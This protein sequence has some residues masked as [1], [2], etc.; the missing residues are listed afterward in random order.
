MKAS[1]EFWKIHEYAT[2]WTIH[3]DFQRVH[4]MLRR[5]R[6]LHFNSASSA[7]GEIA[8]TDRCA[9]PICSSVSLPRARLCSCSKSDVIRAAHYSSDSTGKKAFVQFRKTKK[10]VFFD[11]KEN[12]NIF[13][14][15]LCSKFLFFYLFFYFFQ[16]LINFRFRNF[17]AQKIFYSKNHTLYFLSHLTLNVLYMTRDSLLHLHFSYVI[18]ER[19]DVSRFINGETLR[20]SRHFSRFLFHNS[21]WRIA[22]RNSI[23]PRDVIGKSAETFRPFD[24]ARSN[25]GIAFHCTRCGLMTDALPVRVSSLQIASISDRENLATTEIFAK[26]LGACRKKIYIYKNSFFLYW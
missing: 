2:T 17:F 14:K 11:I 15:R 10:L 9:L 19:R 12:I 3:R 16:V 22:S 25:I 21:D 7:I 24:N 18:S 1:E 5:E 23:K 26:F 6:T 13:E 8:D 4:G 20:K